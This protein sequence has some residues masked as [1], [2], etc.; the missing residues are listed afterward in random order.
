M[1]HIVFQLNQRLIFVCILLFDDENKKLKDLILE[2][3]SIL[4]YYGSSRLLIS[5]LCFLT[6]LTFATLCICVFFILKYYYHRRSYCTE[7]E[8][9][10]RKYLLIIIA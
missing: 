3:N 4:P 7:L 5:I 6:V 10:K 9:G 1:E 8:C 2:F